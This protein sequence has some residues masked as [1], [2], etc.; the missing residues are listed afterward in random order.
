MTEMRTPLDDAVAGIDRDQAARLTFY[1]RLAAA[2][3]FV[4]LAA[5]ADDDI[6]PKVFDTAEGRF[7]LIFDRE[8]R[9]AAF[10]G[11][12]PYAVLS[13][14]RIARMLSGQ[15]IGLVLNAG[16]VAEYA[17][18]D[19]AVDWLAETLSE[20]PQEI[21]ALPDEISAPSDLPEALLIALN[22][23]L[24]LAGGLADLAY[25]CAAR[26]GAGQGHILGF[27]DPV[28]GAEETLAGLVGEALSLSGVEAG[29]LDVMFLKSSDV[30]AARLA[31]HALHFDLPKPETPAPRA[32]PGSDPSSPPILR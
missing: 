8:E 18:P 30:T 10:A 4:L 25:L 11:A 15:G 3:L 20:A 17:I 24:A 6:V 1:R 7:L 5:E 29:T 32:A 28:P 23:A 22:E 14:R 21:S 2:E 27:V 13:G 12:A 26:L 9:L 16:T 31:R 19:T